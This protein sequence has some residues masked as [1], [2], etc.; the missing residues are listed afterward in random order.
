VFH[1]RHCGTNNSVAADVVGKLCEN[2]GEPVY[3]P[4]FEREMVQR[5]QPLK[6]MADRMGDVL[7]PMSPLPSHERVSRTG[8]GLHFP[9][10]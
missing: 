5:P 8:Y 1:C 6:A 10:P 9:L 7:R 3:S 2:C 4:E